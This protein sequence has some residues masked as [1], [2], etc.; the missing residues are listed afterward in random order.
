ML[1]KIEKTM[2]TVG[3]T[4]SKDARVTAEIRGFLR[5]QNLIRIGKFDDSAFPRRFPLDR[6]RSFISSLSCSFMLPVEDQDSC[7][8]LGSDFC[9]ACKHSFCRA[10][11]NEDDVSGSQHGIRGFPGQD[12][13]QVYG[14]LGALSA[15]LIRADDAGVAFRGGF[16]QA[17]A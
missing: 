2:R 17:L 12:L 6:D 14:R 11:R 7:E 15:P 5:F 8:C 4:L 16:G 9:T 10:V 1:N 13:A 3:K